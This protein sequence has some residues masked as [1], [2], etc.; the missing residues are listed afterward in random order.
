MAFFIYKNPGPKGQVSLQLSQRA[1]LP[2][3][4]FAGSGTPSSLQASKVFAWQGSSFGK[5]GQRLL[6][7]S[8]Y[9]GP[10]PVAVIQ[11]QGPSKLQSSQPPLCCIRQSPH[12]KPFGLRNPAAQ[13][14][15]GIL[16]LL[17]VPHYVRDSDGRMASASLRLV[18][19]QK[20]GRVGVNETVS[21][22]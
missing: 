13:V 11:R 16:S 18:A 6:C 7:V 2:Q 5:R 9:Q 21:P 14:V 1:L 20:G 12:P 10:E 3:A 22:A 8:L 17:S 15:N 19:F 4:A